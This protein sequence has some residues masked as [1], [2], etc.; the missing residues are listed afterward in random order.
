MISILVTTYNRK[1][2]LKR[3]MASIF[4][5]TYQDYELIIIDDA[6]TDDTYDLIQ[7]YTDKRIVY[8]RNE[9]NWGA[10][11]GDRIH[12]KRFLEMAKGDYFIYLCDDDYW[13]PDDLLERQLKYFEKYPALSMVVGGQMSNFPDKDI[14][15]DN[16]FPKEYMTSPE[17]LDYFA[18]HPIECNI[19]VG[20]T[21]FKKSVFQ[22]SS[23]LFGEGSKW[24]AGYELFLS[25]AKYGDVVYMNEPCVMTEIRPMNQSF[26]RTQIEHYVDS[27]NSVKA[28]HLQLDLEKK[29][30]HNIGQAYLRN[31]EH[32]RNHGS[33]TMCSLENITR[34]VTQEDLVL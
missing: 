16:V 26:Q 34:P 7:S 4:R 23:A 12:I 8:Y 25:P 28:A 6:S 33:L 5:Q 31:T 1:D 13:I 20:A 9:R 24:Q 10:A 30:L 29:V 21:L 19:I 27:V 15:H 3:A 11:H 22:M 32:I 18:E 14:F 2:L 17:F